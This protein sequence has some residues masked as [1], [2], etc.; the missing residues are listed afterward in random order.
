MWARLLELISL[1]S[2]ACLT[3][4]YKLDIDVSVALNQPIGTLISGS[5]SRKN[6]SFEWPCFMVSEIEA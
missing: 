4:K 5:L 1:T 2:Y 3:H 6:P